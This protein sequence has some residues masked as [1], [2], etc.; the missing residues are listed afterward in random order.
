MRRTPSFIPLR[1]GISDGQNRRLP[2]GFTL[3][4]LL[5][6][7]AIIALLLAIL[8]PALQR[9]KKQAKAVA[10]Q[11][12][13]RQ[14]NTIFSMYADDNDGRFPGWL[15]AGGMWPHLLKVLWPYYKDTDDLFL[16]PMAVKPEHQGALLS[17]GHWGG[18]F[19]AWSLRSGM[20][21]GRIDGSLGLNYWAQYVPGVAVEGSRTS[22][23]WKTASAKGAGNI[24]VLLDSIL[25]WACPSTDGNPPEFDDVWTNESLY[26]CINR[27]GGYINAVFMD[28]SCRKVGLKELWTL[29]WHRNFDTAGPWTKA[30]GVG[31]ED[32]P[33]WMR[34]FKDY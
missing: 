34:T 10:C 11:S 2:T 14:W 18:K 23:F 19:S 7:I 15:S 5:V 4:E 25:W 22:K 6:V 12:N 17:D 29:K 31:P 20:A 33:K 3:I 32:W 24:P 27:H 8:M 26:C 1:S 13:L 21:G 28:W 30:G 9:V 16:C